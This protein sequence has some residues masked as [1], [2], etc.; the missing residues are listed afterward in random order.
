MSPF[1]VLT[2][3]QR[4]GSKADSRLATR[5]TDTFF[6]VLTVCS[7]PRP[8]RLGLV[9]PCPLASIIL[10]SSHIR[11]HLTSRPRAE[12]KGPCAPG[13]RAACH[14]CYLP[15]CSLRATWTRYTCRQSK[16][17][18]SGENGCTDA[19]KGQ[20]VEI[21]LLGFCLGLLGSKVPAAQKQTPP[22]KH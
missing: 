17:S 16:P 10:P 8:A 2:T 1:A 6:F 20:K 14:H 4:V 15:A 11:H 5:L 9:C 19:T 12:G 3:R 21:H 13:L 22:P 7:F 18:R